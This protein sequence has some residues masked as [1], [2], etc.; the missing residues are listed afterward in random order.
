[1]IFYILISI[2]ATLIWWHLERNLRTVCHIYIESG[3]F[4]RQ[5]KS[6]WLR[7]YRF[8]SSNNNNIYSVFHVKCMRNTFSLYEILRPRVKKEKDFLVRKILFLVHL[9]IDS[10]SRRDCVL[11]SQ[12][13]SIQIV[14]HTL[15]SCVCPLGK[16][17]ASLWLFPEVWNA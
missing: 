15:T 9:A 1:M 14:F 7:L 2:K 12:K 11:R 5:R 3:R 8:F 10:L 17:L 6:I 4:F 16:S 13:A